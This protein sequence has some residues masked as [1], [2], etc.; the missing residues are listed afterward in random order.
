[1]RSARSGWPVRRL[2]RQPETQAA[3][4]RAHDCR[5]LVGKGRVWPNGRPRDSSTDLA[6][7]AERLGL[8]PVGI[9]VPTDECFDLDAAS[10]A[11]WNPRRSPTLA[12]THLRIYTPADYVKRWNEHFGWADRVPAV[13][14]GHADPT[15]TLAAEMKRKRITQRALARGIE[16]DPSFI[17]KVFGG[18]K[19][20][21]RSC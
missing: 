7:L 4:L 17:S 5:W 11:G 19:R 3:R 9:H 14:G 16:A 18:K 1:M 20:W 8:I 10:D 15:V 6:V 13:E 2:Q 12:K 21:P